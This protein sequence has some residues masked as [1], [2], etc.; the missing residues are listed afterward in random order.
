[1]TKREIME[2]IKEKWQGLSP[3]DKLEISIFY[4]FNIGRMNRMTKKQLTEIL[5]QIT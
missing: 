4:S 5:F 3:A 2:Q 1:M